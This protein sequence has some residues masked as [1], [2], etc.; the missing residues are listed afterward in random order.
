MMK[1]LGTALTTA[2]VAT[3]TFATTAHAQSLAIDSQ[4]PCYLAGEQFT[5]SGAGFTAGGLVDVQLDGQSLGQINADAAG[6]LAVPTITLG[7]MKGAKSHSLT[8]VDQTNTALTA[9]TS[10]MG[11]TNQ[12]IVKPANAPAGTKRRLKGYG[13]LA[14]PRVFMHVRGNGYSADKRIA[15]PSGPCGTFVTRKLIVPASAGLGNYRVQFDAKKKYSKKTRPRV[16][17]TMR[18]SLQARGATA[19]LLQGFWRTYR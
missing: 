5:A 9:T 2:M 15:K 19:A 12:V 8:V 10:F 18:V 1:R 14:G 3:A 17:G 16:V 7:T 6:N 13:F 11:T 4:R